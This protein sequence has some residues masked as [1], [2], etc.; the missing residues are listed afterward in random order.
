MFIARLLES[1]EYQVSAALMRNKGRG[2]RPAALYGA[3]GL[4]RRVLL[5][6]AIAAFGAQQTFALGNRAYA[7]VVADVNGDGNADLLSVNIAG[8]NISVLLANGNGSFQTQRT[9]AAGSNP[10]S[11]AVA[12]INRDGKLDLIAAN[13]SSNNVSVLLGNGDGTFQPQH[14]FAAGAIARSV[15]VVDLNRDGKLDLIVANAG[16]NSVSVLLGNGDGSFQPQHTYVTGPRPYSVATAVVNGDGRVDLIVPNGSGNAGGNSLSVL[17]GNGDGSFQPQ[18]TFAAGAFPIYATAA[19][20]NRDGRPDLLVVNHNS[21]TISVLLGNGDGTFKPQQTVTTG[22]GPFSVSVADINGDGRSDLVVPNEFGKTVSVLLGNGDGSFQAQKTFAVGTYPL[23]VTV[24]DINGDGRLDLAVANY[25]SNSASVLLGDVPPVVLSIDRANPQDATTSDTT[26]SYTVTFNE[27]VTGVDPGDF[28][29]ALNNVVANAPVQVSGSGAVYTVTITGISGNGTLGLN[30]IDNGTIKDAAGNPLQP[31]GVAEFSIPQ[32]F[33]SAAGVLSSIALGDLNNDGRA[34]IAVAGLGLSFL[35]NGGDGSFQAGPELTNNSNLYSATIADLNGDGKPDLLVASLVFDRG[36]YVLLG[37]GN[38][39][40]ATPHFLATEQGTQ[41]IAVGDFNGD[42]IPDIAAAFL[43]ASD[44][45]VGTPEPIGIFLGNGNGTFQ[46]G[47]FISTGTTQD[48]VVTADVNGDGKTDLIVADTTAIGDRNNIAVMLGNGNG[49]FQSER[50]FAV[51][52]HPD[53]ISVGDLNRDGKLDLA[54]ASYDTNSISVLFGNG[55][56]T[57]LPQQ[58]MAGGQAPRPVTVADVNGDGKPDI[59][60]AHRYRDFQNGTLAVLLGNGNGTFQR[61]VTVSVGCAPYSMAVADINGDGRPDIVVAPGNYYATVIFGSTN[62]SFSGQI[63][64]IQPQ[65]HQPAIAA[66]GP[67]HTFATGSI[68]RSIVTA[69]INSDGKLDAVVANAGA[70]NVSVLLGN[71][72]GT[73]QP[74]HV[75][76]AG[77]APFSVAVA[78]VNNDGKPDLLVANA[79]SN[80]V[81]VFL[82]NGNGTFQAGKFF[83]TGTTPRFIGVSDFNGDGKPDLIVADYGSNTVT[84]LLGNGDGTF[85]HQVNFAIG[86]K[87]SSIAIG[88]FNRDGRLDLAIA[89]KGSNSVSVLLGNGNGTFAPQSTLLAGSHPFSVVTADVNRDGRLDL[90]VADETSNAVSVFLGNGNGTFT[91]QQTYSVG[92]IPAAL[93]VADIN[94]D[95]KPDIAAAN[96]SSNSISVLLGNGD[97]TFQAQKTFAVGTSPFAIALA[98][99]N[100]D[101]R[102]DVLTANVGSN[103]FSVLLGDVPPVVLSINRTSPPGPYTSD[104]NVTYTVTFNEPVTGVDSTDFALA[105]NGVT[106]NSPV[107][108]PVSGSVYNV[109]ISGITGTGTLGL[110]L[111]DNGSIRDAMGNPLQP[112]GVAAFLPTQTFA[113]KKWGAVAVGDVNGDG[114]PDLVV[115]NAVLLGNG[116]GTFQA[117]RTFAG[118]TNNFSATV[119]D[120]NGDGKPDLIVGN[121]NTVGILLGN[122]DGSFQEQKTFASG[123]DPRIT[124]AIDANGDGIPDLIVENQ[125]SDSVS[126][127]LGNGNGTFQAQQTYQVGDEPFS[128]AAVDLNGD[129]KPDLVVANYYGGVSVLLGNGNGTFQP[130][131]YVPAAPFPTSVAVADVNGDG[132][133]DIVSA[134]YSTFNE[135]GVALGNGDGTFKPSETL[136]GGSYPFYVAVSDIN[137]DGKPDIVVTYFY[138]ADSVNV[139]LGNGDGTFKPRRTFAVDR[140]SVVV[141][142]DVNGDGRRDLVVSTQ[143]RS[144]YAVSVMLGEPKGDF[145]GQTY[146]IVPLQDTISGTA[147]SEDITL[148]RDPDGQHIDWTLNQI[149]PGATNTTVA[150]LAIN[151]PNGFTIIGTGGGRG[152]ITLDYSNGNPLPDTLHLDGTF[153]ISGLSGTNPLAGKTVEIGRSTVYIAYSSSDPI[154]AIKSYLR[155]GYNNG[156]WTGSTNSAQAGVITS[157]PAAQN[158]NRT[159]GIGY[160]DSADGLIGNQPA[161]TIELKYT[162]YGDATLSG[163]V[164]FNDFTRLTQHWGQSTGGAWDTGDFNYD[165]SVNLQD[166]T[167]LSRTY[168][169][170]LGSQAAPAVSAKPSAKPRTS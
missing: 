10:V 33:A 41:S 86:V 153:Y 65:Q 143:G 98:D 9:F 129:G 19:D 59:I 132:K 67:Q 43:A 16:S 80:N 125:R 36:I 160:A 140:P 138:K 90:V 169:T 139:F 122:G 18:R 120:L 54:V 99:I 111:V 124:A 48:L 81:T 77:L 26:V 71:G 35:T 88:D 56:G 95:G 68:P 156:A 34:D 76:A 50:T 109:A 166:F 167:L 84:L 93:A 148:Q 163:S 164:G 39:T 30:L 170:S 157:I 66:F 70:N 94:G 146:T 87:P 147:S 7:T 2:P 82:G 108:T 29:L 158:A 92:S 165:G 44:V 134:G 113:V 5:S 100:R 118:G 52:P 110:N 42:G 97:G 149:N 24:A 60:V 119:A 37:N 31:G 151:D 17:L 135:V 46:P 107:V 91:A 137:G 116:D 45:G 1:I 21:S 4:E 58:S 53:S 49:T 22:A 32:T 114:K 72:D 27:P 89:D 8:N 12:D 11:I 133:P 126:V 64:T 57:F 14:T 62:G 69:D 51:E 102:L 101:G 85:Q 104:S 96:Y 161:G 83:G 47:K 75:L 128:V 73:F 121:L 79:A 38:G 40:F 130:Q 117:P 106:A 127:L 78:D 61:Q 23:S 28:T 103:N 3:E 25:G 144:G 115:Y 155:N 168:N 154:A 141:P 13:R 15:A 150:Q 63:Y 123:I 142:A 162:L 20:V 159:T 145:T 136:G 74:E 105:L 55:D 131:V 112:G 6:S 152:S